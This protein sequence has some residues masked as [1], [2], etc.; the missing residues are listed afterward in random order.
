MG[1]YGGVWNRGKRRATRAT[2]KRNRGKE[3]QRRRGKEEK[4]AGRREKPS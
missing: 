1:M 3:E 2:G 4:G